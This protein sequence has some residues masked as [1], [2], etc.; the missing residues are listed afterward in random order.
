MPR[1]EL[2]VPEWSGS[3]FVSVL[4]TAAHRDMSAS[5]NGEDNITATARLMVASVVDAEGKPILTPEDIPA[6]MEKS[7]LAYKRVLEA[8]LKINK[9]DEDDVADLEKN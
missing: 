8:V 2:E 9:L 3:V 7:G 6:L 4:T 1:K 5:R